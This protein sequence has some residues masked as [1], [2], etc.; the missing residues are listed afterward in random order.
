MRHAKIQLSSS[1]LD[2]DT[3]FL[4]EYGRSVYTD[5]NLNGS[6]IK[7]VIE[8]AFTHRKGI[9]SYIRMQSIDKAAYDYYD[10]LDKQKLAQNN[11]FVEPVFLREGQFGSKAIGFFGS[12]TKSTPVYFEFPE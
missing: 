7:I 11:P 12:V 2:N 1:C 4:T 3:V 9:K 6:Q 5:E 8:P 10:Q